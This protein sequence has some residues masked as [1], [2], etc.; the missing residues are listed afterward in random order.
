M[1]AKH[2]PLFPEIDIADAIRYDAIEAF[3]IAINILRAR[4][5]AQVEKA[6]AEDRL[7]PDE[8]YQFADR[9]DTALSQ[10]GIERVSEQLGQSSSALP[11]LLR[12][13]AYT[14]KCVEAKKR[15]PRT[16]TGWI[17]VYPDGADAL[18]P[19]REEA[20]SSAAN[21]RLA[22]VEVTYEWKD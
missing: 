5:E 2:R 8:L 1:T 14:L 3:Y 21:H 15:L 12:N 22:C 13:L 11:E 16:R 9:L 18:H 10:A 7:A 4:T 6:A 19:T 20:E 17:N